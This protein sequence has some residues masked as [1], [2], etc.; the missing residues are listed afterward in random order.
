MSEKFNEYYPGG[1]SNL[2]IPSDVTGY[3]LFIQ[4]AQGCHLTDVDGNEYIEFNGS[5]GPDILGHAYPEFANVLADFILT[6]GT[7]IGSN[8]LFTPMDIDVAELL[9]KYVP[10]AEAVKFTT[11]GTEAVEMAFRIMRAYTGKPRILRLEGH[12]GGWADEIL[13][14]HMKPDKDGRPCITFEDQG[15]S[16]EKDPYATHGRAPHAEDGVFMIPYNDFDALEET[17]DKWHDEIA[18]IHFE[19]VNWDN[20]GLHP[21]P[22]YV[23]KIRELCDKYNVVMSMDEIITGFRFGL[24]GAQE[25][26]GVTPDICTMGKAMGNMIPT[27]CVA[28]KKKIMD[29]VRDGYVLCPGTYPGYALGQM[30]VKTC[31]EILAKDDGAIYKRIWRLQERLMDGM[32]ALADKYDIP[33]TI[34]ESQGV[35]ST[36]FGIPGGRRRLYTKEDLEGFNGHWVTVFQQYMQQNGVFIMYGGRWYMTAAHRDEDIDTALAA[37]DKSFAA[38]KKNNMEFVPDDGT[39]ELTNKTAA[40]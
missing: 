17:F 3:R 33:L 23:E 32:V 19:G 20:N 21:K 24:G 18:G 40:K 14:G 12:Y 29:I 2:R 8:M 16:A 25:Y 37:I 26:L 13:G 11:S 15:F 22:G 27:S 28:G 5:L 7:A 30:A 10:C 31:I 9:R 6:N 4:K 34:T 1:H 39:I 38:M 36:I 35:F